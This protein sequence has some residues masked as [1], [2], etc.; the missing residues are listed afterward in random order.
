[1][2]DSG[3][4]ATQWTADITGQSSPSSPI[5]ASPP[6]IVGPL[7]APAAPTILFPTGTSSFA[8]TTYEGAPK[9]MQ[10]GQI[11]TRSTSGNPTA[12]SIISGNANGW[13]KIDTSGKISV[14]VESLPLTSP[15]SFNLTVAAGD[16][17]NP[18]RSANQTTTM[19]AIT[20]RPT[21]VI[22]GDF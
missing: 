5:W 15:V 18:G 4:D 12:Y 1:M 2:L 22:T 8:F 17:A 16:S 7:R 9:D 3:N 20:L 10:I 21:V 6:R 13:F 11:P 19:V 14:A